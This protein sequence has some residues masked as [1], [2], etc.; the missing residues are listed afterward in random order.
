MLTA[1]IRSARFRLSLVDNPRTGTDF[2][3]TA[4]N[5]TSKS[6][7]LRFRV[8][9]HFPSTGIFELLYAKNFMFSL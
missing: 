4:I 3:S 2:E 9:N 8:N 7:F 6:S 5:E 1:E